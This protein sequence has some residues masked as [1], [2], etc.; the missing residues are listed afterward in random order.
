MSKRLT[1]RDEY[2]NAGLITLSDV[3][4]EIYAVLS[5]SA[6]LSFSEA[7]NCLIETINKL[8]DYEDAEESK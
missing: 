4:P 7:A 1:M 3:M 2:G 5:C 6:G 8:A